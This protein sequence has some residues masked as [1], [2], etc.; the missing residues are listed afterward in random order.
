[1][2]DSLT[3]STDIGLAEDYLR[4]WKIL[5]AAPASILPKSS[6]GGPADRNY[7]LK[8][9]QVRKY[10]QHEKQAYGIN[11]GWT[12]DAEPATA[13]KVRRWFFARMGGGN[14]PVRYGETI[15]LGNGGDPSFIR[16]AH[17]TV[18][19]DL[20]W[21]DTPVYEWKILGGSVG[22]AVRTGDLVAIYNVHARECL[23]HFDRTRG[24]DIGWPSSKTWGDQILDR[25][26]KAL[27]EHADDAVKA[28]LAA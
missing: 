23:I 16:N 21:S 12:D 19:I 22:D 20:D 1:M 25:V 9:Q 4:Q 8:S 3:A 11:L 24:G 5:A 6:F 7:N 18:G 15:A 27:K 10:L 13:A 2:T 28:M 14:A 26:L 17:R